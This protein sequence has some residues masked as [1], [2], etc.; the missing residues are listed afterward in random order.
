M[1]NL[2]DRHITNAPDEEKEKIA[3]RNK[4]LLLVGINIRIRASDLCT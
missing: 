2:F 1:V 4:L 3:Y